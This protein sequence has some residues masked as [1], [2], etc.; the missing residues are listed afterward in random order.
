MTAEPAIRIEGLR[1]AFG[2]VEAVRGIELEIPRGEIFGLVGPDGAGKTTT[3]RLLCG[4]LRAD[5]GH[6]H[7]AG[8]DVTVEPEAVKARLG[9]LSQRF[10]LYGDLTVWENLAFTASLFRLPRSDWEPRAHDLLRM[11]DMDQF[12][13]RL[14]ANLS[15][16][17]K[18]KLALVCS[19]V[20]TPEVLLLDE[21]TTGVDP[22]SRRDFWAIL[23]GLP[24]RGVTILL[25]TP[26]MDEAERCRRVAF[27]AEGR[28]LAC[29]TPEAL[30]ARVPGRMLR[31]QAHP[32]RQARDLLRTLPLVRQVE[33]FGDWLHVTLAPGAAGEDVAAA[34]GAAG[35]Q[36]EG[37]QPADAGLEDVFMALAGEGAD[38]A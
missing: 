37:W 6:A 30:K 19:L 29:G 1:K 4:I 7:V 16:G 8:H 3:M 14:A 20:H 12:T 24:A 36:V 2:N 9:Y 27:M 32:G 17:M 15:G 5:G 26:Y 33:L 13:R 35:L 23:Y 21:P 38:A 31:V 11:C 18:Q 28:I 10:S 22:V 34:L 25:S